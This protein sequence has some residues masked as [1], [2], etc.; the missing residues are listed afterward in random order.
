[1]YYMTTTATISRLDQAIMALGQARQSDP[2]ATHAAVLT[3]AA[4]VLAE[5]GGPAAL[6]DR[7]KRL[8]SAGVFKDTDW[9]HPTIL[10][11]DIAKISLREG[12]VATTTIEALSQLRLLAV[13]RGDYAHPRI[14]P[15]RA[16][17]FVTQVM[18]LNL[19]LLSGQLG[20]A[21]RARPHGLGPAVAALY[22][23]E[24]EA[25]GYESILDSLVAE[26]W[27]ILDQRPIDVDS[28]REMVV[29]IAAC[30]FDPSLDTDNDAAQRL[31]TC[32]F[33]PT[34]SCAEDP[35]VAIYAERLAAMDT[36]ALTREAQ[37]FARAMHGTGLVSAY[38]AVFMRHARTLDADGDTLIGAALGLSRTG[39]D[40]FRYYPELVHALVDEAIFPETA[41]AVYGLARM[42]DRGIL[43]GQTVVAGLWRQLKITLSAQTTATLT[44]ALGCARSPD[45]H[46]LA[47]TLNLL[48]QPLG[49]GQ[50]NNPTC[51]SVIGLS[52]WADNDPDYLLQ[53]LTWAARDDEI[54]FRFE[55]DIV[56]S[57]GLTAGLA[58]QQ[59]LD[60]DPVSMILVPHLDRIYIEMGR[61]CGARDDDLHR[62]IN[63]AFYGWWVGQGF[64]VVTDADDRIVDH[65][66]FVRDF[67]ASY[68]P[69]FNGGLP[70]IH[71]QPAGI[72][73]TDSAA[74]Y[75]GRH[76]ITLRRVAR[77][78]AGQMRVYF[79]N[80]NNDSGQ[81]W[82]QQIISATHAHGEQPG[83]ASLPFDQFASRL[84]VFHY[85]PLEQGEAATVPPADVAAV[86][87]LA[88]DSWTAAFQ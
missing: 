76:A 34:P 80:P 28:V 38:Q 5:K 81:D 32:L 17:Q 41:Q 73:A 9:D 19:D 10:Q 82:G 22:R 52:M 30:L 60:V 53:L 37:A 26:V 44:Q 15:E 8:E 56:S 70:V 87:A 79:F 6:Y 12:G 7:V 49:V 33:G 71:P 16:H 20:E 67:Y 4:A 1:M 78:P 27:R 39:E 13:A 23:F 46:L 36:D 66:A 50:G 83:E 69:D 29:Q 40:V 85:D 47:A 25:M 42:L 84:F 24:V 51:Q 35:G 14:N 77:D 45:V 86:L 64:R 2:G 48:G 63:P 74:R 55:G 11:P 21:D 3:A 61:L 75:V 57:R 18:A 59:P 58:K 65:E 54:L 68:H 62:W 88:T 43:Y 72:A 31:V